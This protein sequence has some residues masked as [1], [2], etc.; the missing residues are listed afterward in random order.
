M[1][2]PP[3]TLPLALPRELYLALRAEAARRGVSM[4]A[5]IRGWIE[6]PLKRLPPADQFRP[7]DDE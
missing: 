1:A 5:I 2:L 7:R 3:L 6:K 4:Q